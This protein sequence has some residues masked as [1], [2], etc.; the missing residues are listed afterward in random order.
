M[1]AAND[2]KNLQDRRKSRIQLDTE[3]AISPRG[4]PS[5]RWG[6]RG[7]DRSVLWLVDDPDDPTFA[8]INDHTL[9]IHHCVAIFGVTRN[10]TK[11]D[12]GRQRLADNHPLPYSHRRRTFTLDRR[13][14]GIGDFIRG[15]DRGAPGSADAFSDLILRNAPSRQRT[16]AVRSR[17]SKDEIYSSSWSETAQVHLLTMRAPDPEERR[18]RRVSKDGRESVRAS[19][20]R[21]PCFASSSG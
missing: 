17:V 21:D 16:C 12:S 11:L 20:L 19:I 13:D 10:G 5:A 14:H 2:R 7:F 3:P 15:T 6:P 1:R 18:L 9:V 4:G 8:R